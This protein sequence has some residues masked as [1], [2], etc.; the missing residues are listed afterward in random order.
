M[1]GQTQVA[2]GG[3]PLRAARQ[4]VG[5]ARERGDFRGERSVGCGLQIRGIAVVPAAVHTPQVAHDK[6]GFVVQR[7]QIRPLE[8]LRCDLD[9]V[10]D[11]VQRRARVHHRKRFA[12]EFFQVSSA[13]SSSTRLIRAAPAIGKP[14]AGR[15]SSAP[16]PAIVRIAAAHSTG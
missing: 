1:T 12:D 15:N 3:E 11:V 5:A 9:R 8:H 10:D 4:F 2:V 7:S 13:T 14:C 16:Q 6:F